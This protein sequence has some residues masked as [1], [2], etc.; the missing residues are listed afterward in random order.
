MTIFKV[1]FSYIARLPVFDFLIVRYISKKIKLIDSPHSDTDLKILF[2]DHKRFREDIEAIKRLRKVSLYF[3]PLNT[4]DLLNGLSEYRFLFSNKKIIID[5]PDNSLTSY[6]K[7]TYPSNFGLKYIKRILPK[8]M[9]A[10]QMNCVLSCGMLYPRNINWEKALFNSSYPFF[11]MHREAIGL[12]KNISDN[13]HKEFYKSASTKKKIHS[14]RNYHGNKLFVGNKHFRDLLIDVGYINKNRISCVG[15]PKIDNLIKPKD[16]K[17]KK[18]SKNKRVV[19]F[20]FYHT[21]IL[22]NIR[23]KIGKWSNDPQ[24]GFYK[25]FDEVHSSIAKFAI[26]NPNVEVIIKI[27]WN[28]SEWLDRILGSL[29]KSGLVFDEISNLVIDSK[30]SGQFLIESSDVVIGFNST[31]ISESLVLKKNT[32]IPIFLEAQKKYKDQVLWND[33]KGCAI[34]K[35][36]K[37]L[38]KYITDALNGNK[39]ANKYS[40]KMA[41]E[42]FGFIDGKNS[43]RLIS[44]IEDYLKTKL[45]T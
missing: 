25:L 5:L 40:L 32:I 44:E 10:S 34:A 20:S 19:F 42:A 21:Y 30:S 33:S 14:V 26:D 37:D 2:L 13:I 17:T 8:I 43:E 27:K 36:S 15:S 45:K 23:Q 12:S 35:S 38:H 18:L 9:K 24:I 1:I 39:F 11:C 22:E 31:V 6:K 41:E 29:E 7:N 3:L 28:E 16:K 4:H